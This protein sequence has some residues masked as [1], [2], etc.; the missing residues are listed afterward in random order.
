MNLYTGIFTW[1]SSYSLLQIV[2]AFGESLPR[3]TAFHPNG[4]P[5]EP[6]EITMEATKSSVAL[7]F[8]LLLP[9][10]VTLFN[11][12]PS[13]QNSSL[14]EKSTSDPKEL[15]TKEERTGYQIEK[16]VLELNYKFFYKSCIT[17]RYFRRH[18]LLVDSVLNDLVERRLLYEGHGETAF[19]DVKRSLMIKTYLK[20]IPA[21]EDKQRFRDDLARFSNIEYENYEAIFKQA[22][23]LPPQCELSAHGRSFISQ[24]QYDAVMNEREIIASHLHRPVFL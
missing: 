20:F 6:L 16:F 12:D 13:H 7:V 22:P 4:V 10:A 2:Q 8:S 9:Q 18:R 15:T 17:D 21:D 19:F 14:G 1:R 23:L 3:S 5:I 24:P 11:Y